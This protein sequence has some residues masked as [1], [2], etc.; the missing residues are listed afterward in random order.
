[1][2]NEVPPFKPVVIFHEKGTI[3]RLERY[4]PRVEVYFNETAYNN[5]K[6]FLDWIRQVYIPHIGDEDGMLVMDVATFHKTE[7]IIQLLKANRILP[8]IIPPGKLFPLAL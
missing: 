4:D 8:A 5:E 3:A 6:L 7:G 2:A 1:M